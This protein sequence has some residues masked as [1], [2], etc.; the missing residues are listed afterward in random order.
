MGISNTTKIIKKG[1]SV[2]A[3]GAIALGGVAAVPAFAVDPASADAT[4]ETLS[5]NDPTYIKDPTYIEFDDEVSDRLVPATKTPA[6]SD[7]ENV[8][9]P[10]K[11][12]TED[13]DDADDA[14]PLGGKDGDV[15]VT[16]DE[17]IS[18]M[19]KT[20]T[21][22]GIS[23]E[24]ANAIAGVAKAQSDADAQAGGD[25]QADEADGYWTQVPATIQVPGQTSS[26]YITTGAQVTHS[27]DVNIFDV[28]IDKASIEEHN[29]AALD[30]ETC[31]NLVSKGALDKVITFTKV[32]EN[33]DNAGT[34]QCAF[35]VFE[36]CVGKKAWLFVS[37]QDGSVFASGPVI[38]NEL[39]G[40]TFTNVPGADTSIYSLVIGE[41]PAQTTDPVNPTPTDPVDPNPTPTT[42]T[43]PVTPT[44]PEPTKPPQEDI[45]IPD[46][47]AGKDESA[48]KPDTDADQKDKFPVLDTGSDEKTDASDK[49]ITKSDTQDANKKASTTGTLPQTGDANGMLA[50]GLGLTA[51]ASALLAAIG[52]RRLRKDNE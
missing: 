7:Q 23:D 27:F 15:I 51:G 52:A 44:D 30:N 47:D 21:N 18:D 41:P 14:T 42:P 35:A 38:V 5:V 32:M 20:D 49:Q 12:S 43:T 37:Y 48:Q 25:A 46:D 36:D 29:S 24:A 19:D 31:A 16:S 26:Y 11:D 10:K 2:V 1:V 6:T 17:Q 28:Y 3:A 39:G 40:V 22:T 4:N 13:S 33:Y 45:V 8:I 34:T 9:K 50:A